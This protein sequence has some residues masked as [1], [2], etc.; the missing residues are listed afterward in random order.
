MLLPYLNRKFSSQVN[1]SSIDS[2]EVKVRKLIHKFPLF[3][4]RWFDSDGQLTSDKHY[5]MLIESIVKRYFQSN[6]LGTKFLKTLFSWKMWDKKYLDQV[7][8]DC[9]KKIPVS[10][11]L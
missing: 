3:D 2:E 8:K 4:Q 9:S 6:G 11:I 10:S 7:L 1:N 5:D